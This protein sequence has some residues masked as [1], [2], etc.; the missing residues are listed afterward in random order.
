MKAPWVGSYWLT[1]IEG[2]ARKIRVRVD[3]PILVGRG[4]YNHVVIDDPR[5][6]RQHSRLAPE[7]DGCFVYDLNSVNGTT[8]NGVPVKRQLL[9]PNDIVCFGA[10]VFRF[11]LV[12][13]D[14]G[15]RPAV[16]RDLEEPTVSGLDRS[17]APES[18]SMMV[19]AIESRDSGPLPAR[20]LRQLEDAYDNLG[21]LYAFMQAISRTIDRGELLQLIGS[22]VLEVYPTAKFV[23]IHLRVRSEQAPARLRLAQLVGASTPV[24]HARPSRGGAGGRPRPEDGD[25]DVAVPLGHAGR[26]G[27]VRAHDRPGQRD[28]RGHPREHQLPR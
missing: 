6:S 23:G 22:K 18:V 5:L 19:T 11:D 3:A 28:A 13:A 25:D 8:V 14:D 21:T 10:S 2:K 16:I 26:L 15:P 27:H 20:D 7:R 9:A 24:E 4:P 12:P 1:G 17:I